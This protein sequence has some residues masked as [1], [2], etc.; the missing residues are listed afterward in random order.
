MNLNQLLN[1]KYLN[2]TKNFKKKNFLDYQKYLTRLHFRKCPEYNKLLKSKKINISKI[3]H[4]KDIPYIPSKIFKDHILKSIEKK[5]IFKIM[6]SS[7]T[8]N[9]NLSNIILDRNT[10]RNQ[11]K[12]L[13][14]IVKSL[15]GETRLPMI[16]IDSK[17]ILTNR[18]KFSARVAGIHGFKNFSKESIFALDDNMK[19]NIKKVLEFINKYKNQKIIIFGF[20]Y[21]IYENFIK[22]LIKYKKKINLPQGII[23]HGGGWKKLSNLNISNLE[24]KLKLKKYCNISNVHN[25]YGM[26][27]QT[28]SIFFECRNGNFHTS[29]FNDVLIR[30]KY[31]FSLSKV[32]ESGIVQV[33]SLIPE[34]YPGHSILTEDEGLMLGENNCGCGNKSKYFKIIGRIQHS[35]I[36]GCSDAY[37]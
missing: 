30:N 32:G 36:R 35:E 1:K 4:I 33:F 17:S 21:L 13:S 16:I 37:E 6:N 9:N 20:T 3:D 29:L 23:I 28:G 14:K 2:Y 27:E 15:I 25:Y 22:E 34:S 19:L 5:D 26:V 10:S 7:G 8:T 18:N 11:I 31:D 12:V 24:F